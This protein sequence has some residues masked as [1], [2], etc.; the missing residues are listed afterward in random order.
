[1]LL[2]TITEFDWFEAIKTLAAASTAVV[3]MLALKNW[4]RQDKAKRE[5]EFLD[6]LIEAVHTYVAVMSRPTSLVR[7]VKIG[8]VSHEPWEDGD[9]PEKS[10]KGAIAYIQ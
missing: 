7:L 1:M 6:A 5:V 2:N 8:M 9:D 4:R 10:V 3:A